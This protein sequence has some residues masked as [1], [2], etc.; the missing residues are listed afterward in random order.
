V[1]VLGIVNI[2]VAAIAVTLSLFALNSSRRQQRFDAILRIEDYLLQGDVVHGRRLLYES[3]RR[4]KLPADKE[5]IHNMVRAITRF[6]S[7]AILVKGG[8]VP[9]SWMLETWHLALQG[10]HPG[11][12]LVLKY[13]RDNW[14]TGNT[15]P[16]LTKLIEEAREFKCEEICCRS[17]PEEVQIRQKNGG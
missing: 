9:K 16:T 2:T 6:D 7:A 10:L 11:L 4:G 14:G 8:L 17:D 1:D 13:Q 3:S 5:E 12:L 15:W